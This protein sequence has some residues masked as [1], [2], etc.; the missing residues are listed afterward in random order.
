M[1]NADTMRLSAIF[2]RRLFS[3]ESHTTFST[4]PRADDLH[5]R[6]AFLIIELQQ[7]SR[8][9]AKPALG[10]KTKENFDFMSFLEASS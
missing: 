2:K 3:N 10:T 5:I 4:A 9:H 8:R 7:E 1:L 6:L